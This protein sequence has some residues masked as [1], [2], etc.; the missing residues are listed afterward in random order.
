MTLTPSPARSRESALQGCGYGS[1][2]PA[3][4]L[5][6]AVIMMGLQVA[7]AA[8]M[9]Y[10]PVPGANTVYS[11]DISLASGTAVQDSQQAFATSN[12]NGPTG[13]AFDA[14]GNA[15][16]SNQVTNTISKFSPQG[17]ALATIGSSAT[18]STPFGLAID[19]Q[20]IL[21]AAN[22]GSGTPQNSVSTFDASGI[23]VSA[24]TSQINRPVGLAFDA[25]DRL[26][27]GNWFQDT[28]SRFGA[29]GTFQATI[30]PAGISGPG[31]L[32][33]DSSGRL[34]VAN[35][36][37]NTVSLFD[38][39]GVLLATIGASA[40]LTAPSGLALDAAGN[41][42][43]SSGTGSTDSLISKFDS[44]GVFQFSW[45]TPDV[46][47][48]LATQAVPEPSTVALMLVACGSLAAF[49][50]RRR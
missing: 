33:I 41:I 35:E 28:V 21:Y 19:S 15:Y 39:G 25:S 40:G 17:S 23:F 27:A 45:T 29:D 3:L 4:I 46:A 10:V 34:L 1:N 16:I 48:F 14:A 9:L 6:T 30:G 32:A 26:Y 20:G 18:L 2:I 37:A 42:Y 5:T 36:N 47:A 7:P 49:R 24:I 44:A 22:Y 43:V 31:G 13:I 8:E 12:L 38:A 11:Y 50:C